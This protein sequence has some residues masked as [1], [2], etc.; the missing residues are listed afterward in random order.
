MKQIALALAL[1]L[2]WGE[3]ALAQQTP[4]PNAAPL[5]ANPLGPAA[6]AASRPACRLP[7]RRER[8]GSRRIWPSAPTSAAISFTP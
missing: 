8:M 2:G 1:A 6:G 4:A 3:A 7:C 5:L